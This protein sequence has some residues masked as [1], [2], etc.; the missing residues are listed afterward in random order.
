MKKKL[1]IINLFIVGYIIVLVLGLI[2]YDIWSDYHSRSGYITP[3]I[4][5]P[6]PTMTPAKERQ[7]KVH[8]TIPYWEQEKAGTVFKEHVSQFDYLS[9]F[10]Y[11][12]DANQKIVPYKD[13]VIDDSI[14][15]FAKQN[16]VKVLALITNLPDFEGSEWDSDR[17]R[18]IIRT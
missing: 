14:I 4:T 2:A 18:S 3:V 8:A 13:A 15:A 11:T 6:P 9:L 17:V 12:L 16:N 5:P 10:W 1:Y 7:L